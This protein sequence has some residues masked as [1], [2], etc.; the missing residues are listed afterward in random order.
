MKTD[1]RRW[2]GLQGKTLRGNQ[3]WEVNWALREVKVGLGG[4]GWAPRCSSISEVQTWDEGKVLWGHQRPMCLLSKAHQ[5]SE[6][7]G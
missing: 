7:L 3:E 4:S 1:L 2:P 5:A 6:A